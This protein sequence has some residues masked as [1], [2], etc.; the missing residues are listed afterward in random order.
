MVTL[1]LLSS[2]LPLHSSS[3]PPLLSSFPPLQLPSFPPLHLHLLFSSSRQKSQEKETYFTFKHKPAFNIQSPG[4]WRT[5]ISW[6][7]SAC[8]SMLSKE[9]SSNWKP[10]LLWSVE[11]DVVD[12][13]LKDAEELESSQAAGISHL[14]QELAQQQECLRQARCRR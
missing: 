2:Y 7:N 3:P 4:Q 5:L 11:E 14:Q 9:N 6:R 8:P 13:K 12:Q 10:S 1:L